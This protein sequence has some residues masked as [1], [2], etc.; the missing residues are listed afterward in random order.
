MRCMRAGCQSPATE[1]WNDDRCFAFCAEHFGLAAEILERPGIGRK[2]TT[3]GTAE[4]AARGK[5]L[6]ADG[7]APRLVADC[8]GV[9]EATAYRWHRE[10]VGTVN[11]SLSDSEVARVL[12]LHGL[13]WSSRKIAKEI[14]RSQPAVLNVIKVRGAV[15]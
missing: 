12:E 9:S 11:T 8:L 2:K 3:P 15:A 13:G 14:R 6:L 4:Q 10:I 7:L 1:T 5:A